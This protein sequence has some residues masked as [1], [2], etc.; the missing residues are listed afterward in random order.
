MSFWLLLGTSTTNLTTTIIS[1]IQPPVPTLKTMND[2]GAPPR[3]KTGD[4]AAHIDIVEPVCVQVSVEKKVALM[5]PFLEIQKQNN[6]GFFH[7]D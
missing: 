6:E 4:T 3:S 1:S 5:G 7:P 2:C